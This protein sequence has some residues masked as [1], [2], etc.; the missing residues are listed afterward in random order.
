MRPNLPNLT[1]GVKVLLDTR[2]CVDLLRE[3]ARGVHGPAH[4]ALKTL[5][6]T[7]LYLSMY[8]VCELSTGA[9][10]SPQQQLEQRRVA[11]FVRHLT[12]LY[13][14]IAFPTLYAEAAAAL[15]RAG[16]PIPVMDLLIGITAK[17]N[18]LPLLTRDRK[19][20]IHI[21]GL[22]VEYYGAAR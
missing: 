21:P 13:P 6:D 14:D 22:A 4:G 20:F 7:R 2:V 10:L 11:D 18:G 19:H 8:S 12:I 17:S 9:F 15:I 16:T 1:P 3:S 5:G